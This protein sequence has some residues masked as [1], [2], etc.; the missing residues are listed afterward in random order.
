MLCSAVFSSDAVSSSLIAVRVQGFYRSDINKNG[1]LTCKELQHALALYDQD[2]H[3]HQVSSDAKLASKKA[4][5]DALHTA[6]VVVPK[7]PPRS[8]R[9]VRANRTVW[10]G[11]SSKQAS[12]RDG[13]QA[14]FGGRAQRPWNATGG[15]AGDT[16]V[17]QNPWQRQGN[18]EG[19]ISFGR[20]NG[21]STTL[22]CLSACW[23]VA[24]SACLHV[25]LFIFSVCTSPHISPCCYTSHSMCLS[26][27]TLYLSF[28]SHCA[29]SSHCVCPCSPC[30]SPSSLC[31][32]S[33]TLGSTA[34]QLWDRPPPSEPVLPL[35]QSRQRSALLAAVGR[36][37]VVVQELDEPVVPNEPRIESEVQHSEP[38]REPHIVATDKSDSIIDKEVNAIDEVA[39]VAA[40]EK[41]AAAAEAAEKAAAAVVAAEEDLVRI[42]ED[43]TKAAIM[44]SIMERAAVMRVAIDQAKAKAAEKT[45]AKAGAEVNTAQ[46]QAAIGKAGLAT[47]RDGVMGSAAVQHAIKQV[48]KENMVEE[49]VAAE[50]RPEEEAVPVE[51]VEESLASLKAAKTKKLWKK[52]KLGA[53]MAVSLSKVT[54]QQQ[55]YFRQRAEAI[56]KAAE[57]RLEAGK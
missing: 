33:D 51:E 24:P 1:S 6:S 49:P 29:S 42:N 38:H 34:E 14:A 9:A 52:A 19:N 26:G 4:A 43:N 16:A 46:E 27:I 8:K 13:P 54:V 56:S 47:M 20:S 50:E 30:A 12:L 37:G 36:Q 10:N 22:I 28:L 39:A 17:L 31:L 32:S 57:A 3:H 48:A 53:K 11:G 25:F 18:G 44:H 40:A 41:E 23:S 7:Q 2:C 15:V 5:A 55:D 45:V 35:R 21:A